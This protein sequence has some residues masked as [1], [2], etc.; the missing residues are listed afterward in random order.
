MSHEKLKIFD[1]QV[2]VYAPD[3]NDLYPDSTTSDF[4]DFGLLETTMEGASRESHFQGVATIVH[5]LLATFMPTNAYFGEKDYQQLRII[6][7]LV[8]QKKLPIKIVDCPIIREKDGLA[9]SS[10]NTRLSQS[11]RKAASLI[12]ETL[13]SLKALKKTEKIS[14]ITSRVKETFKNH[15]R[16]ELDYFCIAEANSLSPVDHINDH[17]ALRAFI[18]VKLGGVRLI[19]N[20]NF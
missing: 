20:V 15:P 2:V 6:H 1:Q 14:Q 16:F 18:A 3:I 19:D 17:Q 5:R 13:S 10:R 4:Y 8:N 12:Y 9:M 7:L 11:D